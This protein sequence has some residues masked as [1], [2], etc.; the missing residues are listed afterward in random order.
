MDDLY[1]DMALSIYMWCD[2]SVCYGIRRVCVITGSDHSIFIYDFHMLLLETFMA[3]IIQNMSSAYCGGECTR[4]E[5]PHTG[6]KPTKY[7]ELFG[8]S[9][10]WNKIDAA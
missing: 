8:F 2:V 1:E 10:V 6:G 9:L 7:I 4:T 3:Y 5:N